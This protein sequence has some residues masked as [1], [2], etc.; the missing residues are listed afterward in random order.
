[1]VYGAVRL[2]ENLKSLRSLPDELDEIVAY[3]SKSTTETGADICTFVMHF[4]FSSFVGF[5]IVGSQLSTGI[6]SMMIKCNY[7]G[8]TRDNW[9]NCLL[10]NVHLLSNVLLAV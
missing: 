10:F 5:T 1:M 6:T 2:T 3:N 7:N 4:S 8:H 9:A